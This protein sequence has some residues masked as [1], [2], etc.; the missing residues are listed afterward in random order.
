MTSFQ[1]IKCRKGRGKYW[2]I[3][4]LLLTLFCCHSSPDL[5]YSSDPYSVYADSV[6]QGP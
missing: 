5:L 1:N 6:V 3:P 4:V 2:L